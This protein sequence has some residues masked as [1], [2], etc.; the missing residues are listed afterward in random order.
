MQLCTSAP[1]QLTYLQPQALII[2]AF[3]AS[4]QPLAEPGVVHDPC[5]GQPLVWVCHQQV[6]KE[7]ATGAGYARLA[8]DSEVHILRPLQHL[9][10]QSVAHISSGM[11]CPSAVCV[12]CAC[13]DLADEG[14]CHLVAIIGCIQMQGCCLQC[15]RAAPAC[16]QTLRTT[17]M[18]LTACTTAS[19]L[20]K[21]AWSRWIIWP[22]KGVHLQVKNISIHSRACSIKPGNIQPIIICS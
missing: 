2:Q 5:R 11:N 13:G 21:A 14:D 15:P 18:L 10:R 7:V 19:H 16:Y 17:C 12:A 6:R 8:G 1:L 3:H 9:R 22:L 4:R 20:C